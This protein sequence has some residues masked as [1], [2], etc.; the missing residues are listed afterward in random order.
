MPQPEISAGSTF[1]KYAGGSPENGQAADKVAHIL[2]E[3]IFDG[4]LRPSSWLQEIKLARELG[5][6]S[7][8]VR[9]TR[10]LPGS[11]LDRICWFCTLSVHKTRKGTLGG[12]IGSRCP[13]R[14]AA[15]RL[16]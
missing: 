12:D 5:V 8:P 1:A 14:R 13:G 2:R 6:S 11:V 4:A 15:W 7:T 10:R 3:A 9:E 16:V